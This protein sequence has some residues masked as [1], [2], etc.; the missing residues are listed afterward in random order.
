M[1][2]IQG[3]VRVTGTLTI[4]DKVLSL[5]GADRVKANSVTLELQKQKY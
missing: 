4:A 5:Q 3:K 2:S 1:L